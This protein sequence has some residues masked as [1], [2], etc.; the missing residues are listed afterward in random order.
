VIDGR[1]VMT[2]TVATTRASL[3][4][5]DVDIYLDADM[6]GVLVMDLIAVIFNILIVVTV[7]FDVLILVML[8]NRSLVDDMVVASTT[9]E[10]HHTKG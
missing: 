4:D 5:L 1:R 8:V 3:L 2:A 7:V 6:G 10:A 9:K